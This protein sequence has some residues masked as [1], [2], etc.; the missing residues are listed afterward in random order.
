LKRIVVHG[1][2]SGIGRA[3][4]IALSKTGCELVL[5]ARRRQLLEELA[6]E[7]ERNGS[8]AVGV[9]CDITNAIECQ[10][11]IELAK[12]MGQGADPVL[13]N[14]AGVAE[15]GDFAS[16]PIPSIEDQIRVNLVG[17]MFAC[18]AFVP[19]ALER[20]SGQIINILS[21]SAITALPGAAS[22]SAS[23]AGLL[24]FGKVLAAEYRKSGLRVS[25]LLPGATD[26]AIW[27]GSSF[28]PD[29]EDM[30]AAQAVA[31]TI[32]DLVLLPADRN[33]DEITIM[34][35]KGIL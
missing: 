18:R 14:S 10:E 13:V 29:K 20:G 30:L 22:Y 25:S 12:G 26:T 5:A 24:M 3:A 7:C 2:R 23:K 34:P 15:F 32:R 31:D 11:L 21:I 9:A 35:P 19:W 27:E 1:A 17:P 4:A 28:V 6:D 8:R 33:I 16:A